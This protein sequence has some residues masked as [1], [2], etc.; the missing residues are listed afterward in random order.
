MAAY[1]G[2]I[3]EQVP[4]VSQFEL[5]STVDKLFKENTRIQGIV[6]VNNA[7]PIS[8]ISKIHFYQ[9]MGSQYGYHLY[10]GKSIELIVNTNSL[11]VDYFQSITE[12]SKLAMERDE[13]DRYDYVIVTKENKYFGVVSIERLLMKLVE[14][15]VEFASFLNP[16]TRLPGNHIIEEKLEE[17]IQQEKFSILYFDLD[18]FKA[19]NDTYGFRKGD[20]LLQSTAEL[21]KRSFTKSGSF[22]GHIGGDDFIAV[23]DHHDII[24][25]CSSLIEDF[26]KIITEFYTYTHLSQQY[27][28][29]ENR[30]GVIE[31]TALVSLSIAIVTNQN[32]TFKNVE[33]LVEYAAIVKKRC[34]SVSGSC[35]LGSD[36]RYDISLK[37]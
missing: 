34:K 11:I 18:H 5:N 17:I 22:L 24:S 27:V 36:P 14:V 15:Q 4:C 20:N 6:V 26:E 1:I 19:Y 33:E 21:L 30:K 8:L 31:K 37:R 35:Y 12:I 9:K 13:K 25:I 10:M 7:V 16:L 28:L 2:D 32:H 29:A 3:V 23:V